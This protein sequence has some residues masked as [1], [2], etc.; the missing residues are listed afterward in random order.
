MGNKNDT[1]D[2]SDLKQEDLE[3]VF[4]GIFNGSDMSFED[5]HQNASEVA[6]DLAPEKRG[7]EGAKRSKTSLRMKY[8]SQVQEIIEDHG[9]LESIRRFLG[10]SKRKICQLLLVDP[11]AWTRWTREEGRVPPHVYR[12]LQWYLLLQDKHPEYRSSLWLNGVANAQLHPK[13]VETLK[14]EVLSETLKRWETVELKEASEVFRAH[15]KLQ[16]A[17]DEAKI[18]Q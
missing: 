7:K 5:K 17:L 18:K 9:D 13:E 4:E 15:R 3:G 16:K 11:S 12:A 10:L 2:I 1:A 14:S 6:D 8:E